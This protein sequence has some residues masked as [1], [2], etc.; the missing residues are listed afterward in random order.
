M[1]CSHGG[2]WDNRVHWQ[3]KSLDLRQ[4]GT[5]ATLIYIISCCLELG[6]KECRQPSQTCT[7]S[8]QA[9]TMSCPAYTMSHSST[10]STDAGATLVTSLHDLQA[11]K[12]C[13]AV[14]YT[15][16]EISKSQLT[17]SIYIRAWEGFSYIVSRVY[18]IKTIKGSHP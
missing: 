16:H 15:C 18:R 9:N 17:H 1:P 12:S 10:C 14:R 11:G 4:K 13:G 8:H 3:P 5:S 6:Q 2:S 7:I